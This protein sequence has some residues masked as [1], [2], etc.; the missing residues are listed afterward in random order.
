MSGRK[1]SLDPLC[2]GLRWAPEPPGSAPAGVVKGP[3][4]RA[5]SNNLLQKKRDNYVAAGV[6]K[7]QYEEP[8]GANLG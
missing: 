6:V 7:Q 3:T 8:E 4:G 2:M 1:I 5:R